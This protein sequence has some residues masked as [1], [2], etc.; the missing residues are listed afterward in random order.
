MEQVGA[1]GV[2][3]QLGEAPHDL[4]GGSV[5]TGQVV[6]DHHAAAPMAAGRTGLIGLDLRRRP[7]R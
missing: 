2:V 3:T 4:L 7:G 1:H 6:D 5:V